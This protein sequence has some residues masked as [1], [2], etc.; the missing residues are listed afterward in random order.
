MGYLKLGVEIRLRIEFRYELHHVTKI[1][2]KHIE[3]P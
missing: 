3:L 1:N 2:Q